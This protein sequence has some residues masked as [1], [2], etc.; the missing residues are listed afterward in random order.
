MTPGSDLVQL[1]TV[2]D[3]RLPSLTGTR[4]YHDDVF[5]SA[6]WEVTQ[7][8]MSREKLFLAPYARCSSSPR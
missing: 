5:Q 2:R 6:T 7:V 1:G 3:R 4:T 8:S